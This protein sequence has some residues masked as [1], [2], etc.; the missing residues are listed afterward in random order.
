MP[1]GQG[2]ERERGPVTQLRNKFGNVGVRSHVIRTLL[3]PSHDSLCLTRAR[4]WC[5]LQFETE[6]RLRNNVP[7]TEQNSRDSM[8]IHR[9]RVKAKQFA[10]QSS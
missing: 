6:K 2:R 1:N 3:K 8:V 10:E 5:R 9:H 4:C 7:T